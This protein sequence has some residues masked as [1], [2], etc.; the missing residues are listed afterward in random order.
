MAH[1]SYIYPSL[2]TEARTVR[3]RVELPNPG[4]KLKLGMYGNV[5][6]QT[7]AARALVVPKEAV[8]EQDFGNSCSWIVDKAVMSRRQSS[9]GVGARILWKCWK[10]SKKEIGS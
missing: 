6:L 5:T 1:V 4:L 2:N 8:L 9:W 3:V 10:D 7:D